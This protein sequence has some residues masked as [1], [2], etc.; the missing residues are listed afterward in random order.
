MKF[1]AKTSIHNAPELGLKLDKD[2]PNF[3]HELQVP[4]GHAFEIAKDA[5]SLKGV[6]KQDE[7]QLISKLVMF[8]LVVVDDG[9]PESIDAIKVIAAEVKNEKEVAEANAKKRQASAP[10]TVESL[11]K[12]LVD[13][14][15]IK[16]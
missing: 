14:G 6:T 4:K 7:K 8:D 3:Q 13:A 12:T 9:T 10:V 1:V 5:K 15:L 11:L 16:K 2:V